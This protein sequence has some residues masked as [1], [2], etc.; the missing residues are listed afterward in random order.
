MA[1]PKK[2]DSE[3]R[4]LIHPPSNSIPWTLALQPQLI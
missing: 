4:E 2:D 3:K 1:G